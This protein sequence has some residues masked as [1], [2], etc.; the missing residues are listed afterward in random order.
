MA[1]EADYGLVL[2]DGESPGSISNVIEMLKRNK[3]VVVYL[4]PE[5]QFYAVE[6]LEDANKL[7]EK[8]QTASC[9]V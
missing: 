2:W 8:C 3:R 5:K 9:P 4:S 1:G 7:L 6:H